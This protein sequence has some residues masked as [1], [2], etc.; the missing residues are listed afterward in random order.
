MLGGWWW[1]ACAPKVDAP[2]A[3]VEEV[4]V[5][6]VAAAGVRA[7][8]L[9]KVLT[10][11]WDA[12]MERFPEW[13][14]QLGDHRFDD[15]L[16][17]P[18]DAARSRWLAREQEWA[19]RVAV[20]PDAMLDDRDRV[21]RDL[22]LLSLRTDLATSVCRLHEWSLSARANALVDANALADDALVDTPAAGAALLARLRALPASIDAQITNLR[23]GLAAGRVANADSLKLV[24]EQLDRELASAVADSPL[25]KPA[26]RAGQG[27]TDAERATFAADLQA[28]VTD[29]I[30]PALA[31]YRDVVRD[32]LL[33]QARTGD[34]IG[35][36]AL[37]DGAA[38]Y[39]ALIRESTTLDRTAEQLH[40]A[41]L[42]ELER[43][44]AEFR[45]LGP[46]TL[47]TSDLGALFDKLRHD[48]AMHFRTAEEVQ[49]KA[50]E[51]LRRAEAAAPQW[52]GKVP[53]APCV[54]EPIPDYL[55]PYTYVAYYQQ[56]RPDGSRPGV[57]F[58]NT[59]AP[60]TRP[61]FEAEVLAFHESVPGHH[62]QIASAQELG[63]LPAFRRYEGWTAY[64]EGWALYVERLAD[65]M[66]LYTGDTDRL[67][68]LS[69]DAWRA[70]R[71]VVDT[72]VH[73][74]G[75]TR[76][77]AVQFMIDNTPLAENNVRNEVD[78]YITWPG[79]ALAYKVGQME[80]RAL[81]A[82]AEETLGDDFDIRAFHD[83]LLEGGAVSLP[84]LRT[85]VEEWIQR[86]AGIS[87]G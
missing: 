22:L 74:K 76:E 63:E 36:G 48:P 45:A 8:A 87:E 2:P 58:V 12:R 17:D 84:I 49:A 40:Q 59:Y 33:P 77:Q 34:R 10:E 61:R 83:V 46:R 44:H 72:G 64:V 29:A 79:Q 25:V 69:F 28:A 56:A 6:D 27:W 20:L 23:A 52:F 43:I 37:P 18:S 80:I 16:F 67:G 21:T 35:M 42:A 82:E 1:L 31:R 65:E 70:S 66:G 15:R 41:G 9:R 51:A 62:F 26:G 14:T 3:M 68:M 47:G 71:L 4:Q 60:E 50:E 86:T 5:D 38:C 54:V 78:R 55:A 57:Y 11:Y 19:S 39:Q 53:A 32:E 7:P 75:W 24:V 85:R 30:R 81:R 13:A 73:A